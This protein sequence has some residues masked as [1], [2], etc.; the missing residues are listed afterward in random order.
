LANPPAEPQ[1]LMPAAEKCH[2]SDWTLSFLDMSIES[3]GKWGGGGGS[4]TM[5]GR[6]LDASFG[7]YLRETL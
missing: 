7:F 5:G 1:A 4:G 6:S 3:Q 2:W